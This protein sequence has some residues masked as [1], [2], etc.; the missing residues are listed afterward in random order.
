M[1]TWKIVALIVGG[2]LFLKSRSSA[3][4]TLPAYVTSGGAPGA[5]P[6]P[7]APAPTPPILPAGNQMYL[8]A[9]P[10]PDT[11]LF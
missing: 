5:A 7:V 11:Y 4:S 1:K 8:G 6:A 9:A 2:Y 10:A 3:S